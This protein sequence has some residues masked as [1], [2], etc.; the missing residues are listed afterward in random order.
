[1][2]TITSATRPSANLAP[3]RFAASTASFADTLPSLPLPTYSGSGRFGW[4]EPLATRIKHQ[5][6]LHGQTANRLLNIEL[7]LFLLTELLPDAP[8]EALPDLLM[9][10]GMV[11]LRRPVWTPKQHRLLS[12]GRT[13]LAPYQN[14]AVW[15]QALVKYATLPA[16]ARIYSLSQYGSIT[17]APAADSGSYVQRERLT[18]FWRAML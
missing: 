13:L 17:Q 16:A 12:R 6:E 10:N 14:R 11:H 2:K 5:Y 3:T 4:Q 8:P 1:M 9:G 15:F 7:G 18:L